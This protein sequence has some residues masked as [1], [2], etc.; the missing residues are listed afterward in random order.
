MIYHVVTDGTSIGLAAFLFDKNEW[1]TDPRKSALYRN[2]SVLKSALL[3]MGYTDPHNYLICIRV[4][5]VTCELSKCKKTEDGYIFFNGEDKYYVTENREH[6]LCSIGYIE[7]P[8]ETYKKNLSLAFNA[9]MKIK[10]LHKSK[11]KYNEKVLRFKTEQNSGAINICSISTLV[12]INNK[13]K[14]AGLKVIPFDKAKKNNNLVIWSEKDIYD[15]RCVE[16][17]L[18]AK[19][20]DIISEINNLSDV[21]ITYNPVEFIATVFLSD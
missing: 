18:Q 10:G 5:K 4:D 13:R 3:H 6:R 12:D 20:Y 15:K 1:L 21:A 11:W 19:I 9:C 8:M 7:F 2:L 17:E 14:E 16:E